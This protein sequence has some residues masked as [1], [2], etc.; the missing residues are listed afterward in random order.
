MH[1]TTARLSRR[2]AA[3]GIAAVSL[4]ALTSGAMGEPA[5][6]AAGSH[7]LSP[8]QKLLTNQYLVNGTARLVMQGDGNLVLYYNWGKSNRRACWATHTTGKG[9][10]YAIM[11]GDGNFVVYGPHGPVWSA[12]RVA[13][14]AGWNLGLYNNGTGSADVTFTSPDGG[15]HEQTGN[16]ANASC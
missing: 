16:L 9:G 10:T 3:A 5:S 8:G 12:G 6:A 4:V 13:R 7:Y 14:H 2:L 11:Q 15:R 1:L